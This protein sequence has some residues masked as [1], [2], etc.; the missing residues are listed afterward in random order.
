MKS[1]IIVIIS[2]FLLVMPLYADEKGEENPPP[3]C[4]L[5][6]DPDGDKTPRARWTR[7]SENHE[8]WHNLE[9]DGS[10]KHKPKSKEWKPKGTQEIL[11]FNFNDKKVYI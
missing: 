11:E 9:E 4:C 5:D 1:L 7:E 2:A 10:I 8:I 3:G 6:I